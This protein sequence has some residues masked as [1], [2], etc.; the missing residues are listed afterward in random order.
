MA[1]LKKTVKRLEKKASDTKALLATHKE[2]A[3]KNLQ[4]YKAAAKMKQKAA[5]VPKIIPSYSYVA[6]NSS[7]QV[8]RIIYKSGKFWKRWP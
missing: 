5:D 3:R 4:K 6:V 1:T 7:G 2:A 8:C